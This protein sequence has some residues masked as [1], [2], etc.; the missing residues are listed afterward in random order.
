MPIRGSGFGRGIPM[1]LIK[2]LTFAGV[3][4]AALASTSASALDFQYYAYG[5]PYDGAGSPNTFAPG[6]GGVF[7]PYFSYTATQNQIVYQYLTP[8]TW[9]D[10]GVSLNTNGLFIK[11]G[12]LI[13]NFAGPITSVSI[14]PSSTG[15]GTFS[16]SNVTFNSTAVAVEWT[17]Q[18]FDQSSRL[19]LNL[20]ARGGAVPEP[21][22]WA[23]LLLGFGVLG[24][25]LRRSRKPRMAL[26]YA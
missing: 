17:G 20:N 26:T 3:A 5:G 9:S 1:K 8:T 14:D 11:N 25:A 4:A 16:L 22:T 15:L 6:G 18:S 13:Y 2:A 7:S 12:S 23:M 21:A 24:G 10:S 19:V